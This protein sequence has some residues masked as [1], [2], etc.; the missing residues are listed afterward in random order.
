IFTGGRAHR[1]RILFNGAGL[2]TTSG[3]SH[4]IILLSGYIG[5]VVFGGLIYISGWAANDT[6]AS[7]ILAGLLGLLAISTLFLVRDI[8]TLLI[9]ACIAAFLYIPFLLP[10]LPQLAMIVQLLG[11]S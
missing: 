2:C 10:Q 6:H 7:Y 3:G 1:L 9:I 5:A 4:F 11:L 8:V